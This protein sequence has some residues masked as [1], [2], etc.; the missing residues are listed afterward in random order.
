MTTEEKKLVARFMGYTD[1]S[2]FQYLSHPSTGYDTDIDTLDY[3]TDWNWIMSV[4]EKICEYSLVYKEE[5]D[6]KRRIRIVADKQ[7]V[8][9]AAIQFI[10]WY[11]TQSK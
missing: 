10:Q 7:A 6:K 5:V 8:I 1:G 2:D 9:D 3:D 4:V 11:N